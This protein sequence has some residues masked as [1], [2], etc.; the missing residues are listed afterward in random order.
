MPDCVGESAENAVKSAKDGDVI[1]LENLR[2]HLEEEGKGK[3]AEGKKVKASKE[4]IKKF[5][6][7]LTKLGD[8]YVNDAFGTAHRAHR[9]ET[10]KNND[11]AV[12]KKIHSFTEPNHADAA[13]PLSDSV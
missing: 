4:D 12:T 11:M 5:R 1:L 7:Q 13:L 9:Y 6:Q 8:V 2:F 10:R 3:D